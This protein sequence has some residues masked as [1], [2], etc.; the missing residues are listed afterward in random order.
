MSARG[1]RVAVV[2]GGLA[3]LAASVALCEAGCRVELFEARRRL[4]GR[5]TSFQDPA[6]GEQI[7]HCQHVS[8]G[9]CTNL[10]DFCSRVGVRHLFRQDRTLHFIGRDGACYPFAGSQWWPAPLHLAGGLLGL[11]YLS[12]GERISI[13]QAMLRLAR[14]P[15]RC[16]ADEPT[17]GAWLRQQRQSARAIEQFWS[18][19]LVSALSEEVDRAGL[20]Y[21][22][23]V[24]VDG[25]MG[26][27]Q[28]YVVEV[29]AAPLDELYGAAMMRWFETHGVRLRLSSP[30][31]ELVID[32]GRIEGLRT[33]EGERAAFDAVVLAAPWRR[34]AELLAGVEAC[35][36]IVDGLRALESAPITGVH[37][38]FDREITPLPHAVLVG[39]LS[40]WVFRRA[41]EGSAAQD[42]YYQVVISA[43]RGL[44]AEGRQA[45]IDQVVED[46]RAVFP[47]ARG[48]KLLRARGVT[49]QEAVFSPVPGVDRFRPAQQTPVAGLYLAGDWTATDWPATME[50]A[51]RGGYMAADALLKRQGTPQAA[52]RAGL[53]R[54]LVARLLCG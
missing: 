4:G 16:D 23:K 10:A 14:R 24:F 6:S 33:R 7:D 25:F 12:R 42:A 48:A 19:V 15:V 53:P 1:M 38:W 29:P 18:V 54:S 40:Q 43:S 44:S 36:P 5:A 28:G 27:R 3:G 30:V 22:R 11:G 37:L 21:A 20:Y 47:A 2:G 9:C 52:L 8:M 41:E 31:E 46:L 51:V 35:R 39:R 17:I 50:G 32:D 45:A 49:E 26:N 13:A 34:A